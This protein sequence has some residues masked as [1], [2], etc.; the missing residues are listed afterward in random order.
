MRGRMPHIL[1]RAATVEQLVDC[2]RSSLLCEY[3]GAPRSRL[4]LCGAAAHARYGSALL[5]PHRQEVPEGDWF[6]EGCEALRLEGWQK[7][8]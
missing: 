8:T 2:G 5:P 4:P 7:L 3:C 1:L 6:C